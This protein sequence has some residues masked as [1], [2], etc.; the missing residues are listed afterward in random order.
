M[1]MD[2]YHE[3]Q[4]DSADDHK[5]VNERLLE[6]AIPDPPANGEKIKLEDCLEGYFNNRI[7][8]MRMREQER[9]N[10]LKRRATNASAQTPTE[11]KAGASEHIE[12]NGGPS[13]EEIDFGTGSIAEVGARSSKVPDLSPSSPKAESKK[14][15]SIKAALLRQRSPSIIKK[16]NDPVR[17]GSMR[18]AV[19]MPAWQFFC[20]LPW[21]TENIPTNDAQVADHFSQKRPVLGI[22]L[23]RYGYNNEG[24]AIRLDT[25]IDIPIEI[26]LPTFIENDQIDPEGPIQSEFKLMLQSIVCHKGGSVESGHYV[27]S[28]RATPLPGLRDS[29]YSDCDIPSTPEPSHW[30]RLDDLATSGRISLVN[31]DDALRSTEELPYLLFYQIVPINEESDEALPLYAANEAGFPDLHDLHI[32][33]LPSYEDS[34]A[35]TEITAESQRPSFEITSPIDPAE[36]VPTFDEAT[37]GRPSSSPIAM[38]RKDSI[39]FA[40]DTI[41][42]SA[43]F[44][45]THS[46]TADAQISPSTSASHLSLQ[47]SPS[48]LIS[49]PDPAPDYTPSPAPTPTIPSA[50]TMPLPIGA[51]SPS[52]QASLSRKPSSRFPSRDPSKS[53][54]QSATG[55]RISAALLKLGKVKAL[56]R[57]KEKDR[58]D[59]GKL[60]LEI[61]GV[62]TPT[63]I[64]NAHAVAVS[65]SHSAVEPVIV[66]AESTPISEN[67]NTATTDDSKEKDSVPSPEKSKEKDKDRSRFRRAP[68]RDRERSKSKTGLPIT[69]SSSN[70]DSTEKEKK[71][72]DKGKGKA[73]DKEKEKEGSD[74]ENGE[75]KDGEKK[76]RMG[77]PDRECVVM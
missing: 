63:M 1:K 27:S 32:K 6:V 13:T 18:N 58:S 50:S 60:S 51:Q 73:K 4:E 42:T 69:A 54:S 12:D 74:S 45:N 61:P 38:N 10:S 20:L 9:R 55:E 5:F 14:I 15:S 17:K 30:M 24:N 64:Y 59:G 28:I 36:P 71:D 26:A 3:G 2:I 76:K 25:E 67:G 19:Q 16:V 43:T 21:Y 47:K 72:K 37:R 22:C 75:E 68:R 49:N 41:T 39:T 40:L 62:M 65:S 8:V 66:V 7:E 35:S 34:R 46:T 53:R 70:G 29:C 33:S 57:D 52:I 56:S 48:D 23:K 31:I 11:E 44:P 77:I